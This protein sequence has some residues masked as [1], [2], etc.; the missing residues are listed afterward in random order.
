MGQQA[1]RQAAR[2]TAREV[3]ARRRAD[4]AERERRLEDL[5]VQVLTALKERAEAEERAGQALVELTER[6]S[7]SLTEAVQWCDGLITV[8]EATRLRR[9]ARHQDATPEEQQHG[10]RRGG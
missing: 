4:R 3:T 1:A 8:R 9:S 2:R 6:E 5:V 10:D 7:L